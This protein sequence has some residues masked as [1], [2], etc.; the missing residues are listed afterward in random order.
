[1]AYFPVE[2]NSI[3][4]FDAFLCHGRSSVVQKELVLPSLA[5]HPGCELLVIEVGR[6]I[7]IAVLFLVFF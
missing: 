7:A 2:T 3:Q 5:F 4:V 6:N 1:M